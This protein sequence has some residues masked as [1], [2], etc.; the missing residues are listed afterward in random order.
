MLE[1]IQIKKEPAGNTDLHQQFLE[2]TLPEW[3]NSPGLA[4]ELIRSRHDQWDATAH[5]I[6]QVRAER[7]ALGLPVV[8]LTGHAPVPVR[9]GSRF[10]GWTYFNFY[11]YSTGENHAVLVYGKHHH[12][13]KS[14]NALGDGEKVL[15]RLH[16]ATKL[17]DVFFGR[18]DGRSAC[19]TVEDAMTEI[20]KEGRG[21]LVYTE[22]GGRGNGIRAQFRSLKNRFK[23]EKSP[24]EHGA[25]RSKIVPQRDADGKAISVKESY[26]KEHY[27]PDH[28]DYS[29]VAEMLQKIGVKSV[30]LT[31]KT[32][33]KLQVLAQ[34]GLPVYNAETQKRIKPD[35]SLCADLKVTPPSYTQ[36]EAV[37]RKEVLTKES[38]EK[39]LENL[40]PWK[41]I[42]KNKETLIRGDRSLIEMLEYAPYPT[43]YGDW[44]SVAFG[45][46][47]TG[48]IHR[49]L[50]FGEFD[51]Q[52]A[53]GVGTEPILIRVHSACKTNEVF[54]STNCEC[55]EE[56]RLAMEKIQKE[57]RGIILY[58]DQEG[59]GNGIRGKMAQLTTMFGLHTKD[60]AS[61]D[62]RM[63]EDGSIVETAEA[64]AH[65][66]YP[67][68]VRNF[69]ATLQILTYLRTRHLKVMTNNPKKLGDLRS[70]C[71]V[72]AVGI[73]ADPENTRDP[74]RVLNE[75]KDK[76]TQLG[77]NIPDKVI[78]KYEEYL[79]E[80]PELTRDVRLNDF[81]SQGS[82]P[83]YG[84]ALHRSYLAAK[85]KLLRV[86]EEAGIPILHPPF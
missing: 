46:R 4:D 57:G 54:C 16:A 79:K 74:E 19:M 7:R 63:F 12:K 45:D 39:L 64:Y 36:S 69:A 85:Y 73:F 10:C 17:F 40:F 51:P 35:P 65:M 8:T 23:F 34:T 5:E 38:E 31:T 61:V 78:Q 28:P 82:F 27:Y 11:D 33:A 62:S 32:G 42:E 1:P 86:S 15:V 30:R 2:A 55:Q 20:M 48:E 44:T 6:A 9:L 53:K 29:I 76:A 18:K 43:E 14:Q 26:V 75:L 67:K 52:G 47:T 68:E 21:V 56:L 77:H 49:A 59:R 13:S 66:G 22:D 24:D 71:T 41:F 84:S 70:H 83:K 60:P 58:M 3:S 25:K 37:K 72:E 50:V 80:H 81:I